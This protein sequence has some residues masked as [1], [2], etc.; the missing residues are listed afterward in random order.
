M[1]KILALFCA[2]LMLISF[3]SCSS[4]IADIILEELSEYEDYE[5]YEDYEE[6][7][8][9]IDVPP[10]ETPEE[11]PEEVPEKT[12]EE[13]LDEDG[14]YYSK[15]EVAL[16]IHQ[17]GKLP[18]NYIT[19]TKAQKLGWKYGSLEDFAPG[20]CIGGGR[21]YNLEG[22]LPEKDGRKYYEC[23]IGTLGKSERGGKRIVYSDDGLIYYTDDHYESFTLLYG[24]E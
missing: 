13:L 7:D 17:Y 23:D 24:E 9:E 2:L 15:D 21:F 18:K 6:P 22:D 14:D 20:K 19:K 12:P 8:E 10:E 4:E 11:T 1:K 3:A 16:Y 5:N